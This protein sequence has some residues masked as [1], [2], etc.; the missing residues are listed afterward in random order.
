MS[1][2]ACGEPAIVAVF[3]PGKS[4]PL[5]MCEKHSNKAK[6]IAESLGI[7]LAMVAVDDDA[8]CTQ[9]VAK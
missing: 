6:L 8:T 2:R 1:W 4:N 3:W 5:P 9:L 7:G